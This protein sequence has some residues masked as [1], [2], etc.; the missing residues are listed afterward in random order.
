MKT[1][2]LI[3]VKKKGSQVIG[4]NVSS[5]LES[6]CPAATLS[7]RNDI[8]KPKDQEDFWMLQGLKKGDIFAPDNPHAG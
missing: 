6:A 1:P 2:N 8:I 5:S 4:K 3:V 7:D